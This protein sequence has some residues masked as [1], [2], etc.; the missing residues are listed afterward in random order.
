MTEAEAIKAYREML[1]VETT[2]PEM[3]TGAIRRFDMPI[4]LV[5]KGPGSLLTKVFLVFETGGNSIAEYPIE[6]LRL[7]NTERN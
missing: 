6:R 2:V 5:Y 4:H 1:P 7:V 3:S